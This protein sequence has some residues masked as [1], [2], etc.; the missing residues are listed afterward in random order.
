ME[1]HGDNIVEVDE[2]A[3][4]NDVTPLRLGTTVLLRPKIHERNRKFFQVGDF[5]LL[6]LIG[7]NMN[8]MVFNELLEELCRR[9]QFGSSSG[10]S[11][12]S[13]PSAPSTLEMSP[14]YPE[15]EKYAKDTEI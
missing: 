12:T 3:R 10:A 7:Q 1:S 2:S 14:M 5:L 8:I 4:S 13:V 6:H 15:I 11:P 9:L